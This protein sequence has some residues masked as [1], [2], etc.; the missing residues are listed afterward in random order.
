MNEEFENRNAKEITKFFWIVFSVRL[1]S[2]RVNDN[3]VLCITLAK[4]LI[5]R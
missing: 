4:I 3:L 5:Q 1:S 2:C